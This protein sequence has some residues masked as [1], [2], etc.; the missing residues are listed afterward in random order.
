VCFRTESA[1]LAIDPR[2]HSECGYEL[3]KQYCG[4]GEAAS[5]AEAGAKVEIFGLAP[6]P[7]L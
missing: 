6:A 3:S 2:P 5:F 1:H 7:G 4:V